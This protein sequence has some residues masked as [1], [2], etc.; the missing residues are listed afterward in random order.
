VDQRGH[1]YGVA[2]LAGRGLFRSAWAA[3]RTRTTNIDVP[4]ALALLAGGV[5]GLINVILSRGAIYFD[6]LTVLV[7]LL[8]VGRFIQYRQQR[9][10]DDAVGLL[11]QPDASSCRIVLSSRQKEQSHG[12]HEGDEV[13]HEKT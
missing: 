10:A 9:R 13:R 6:S 1:G 4:I 11:F 8:L 2:G 7:F 12:R 3:I 5:A